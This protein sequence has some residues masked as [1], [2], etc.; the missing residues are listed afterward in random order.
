MANQNY[1]CFNINWFN[2]YENDLGHFGCAL[3]HLALTFYAHQ[4]KLDWIIVVEDDNIF[5]IEMSEVLNILNDLKMNINENNWKI[6]NGCPTMWN[7]MRLCCPI[8]KYEAFSPKF[9][10]L[11]WG[12]YTNFMIYSKWAYDTLLH[13][14]LTITLPTPCRN[15]IYLDEYS[16]ID[17]YI[18][19]Y[20]TTLTCLTYGK[21]ITGQKYSLSN[22]NIKN[23][24]EFHNLMY[25]DASWKT[26]DIIK[27]ISKLPIIGI[28]GIFINNYF[29]FYNDF[30]TN[31]NALFASDVHKIFFI[32]TDQKIDTIDTFGLNI[33]FLYRKHIGWPYETL[34]RY[35]YF[36]AFDKN[37]IDMCDYFFFL[38]SNAQVI[39]PISWKDICRPNMITCSLHNTYATSKIGMV[40]YERNKISTAFVN[41][42]CEKQYVGGR[43]FGAPREIFVELCE[44]LNINI[45]KDEKNNFI[46]KWH[47][48]SHLNWYVNVLCKHPI[49]MLPVEY[50]VPSQLIKKFYDPI[51]VYT[52]KSNELAI[53]T[54]R[55]K[56]GGKIIKNEYNQ[57]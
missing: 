19:T 53:G 22:V 49:Y 45:S 46:A 4:K 5:N 48:E 33:V 31:I 35:K 28:F 37:K 26:I 13:Y 54:T 56:I 51:I 1:D 44:V 50:H 10:F 24:S 47:D 16:H 39:R 21:F 2:A 11:S 43:L 20:F 55:S 18:P 3:S 40:P 14:P 42:L 9:T 30:I 38:N 29:K 32:V 23:T 12:Q 25:C 15:K 8:Y 7:P 6:F 27:N 36:L 17:T 34:Y 52:C 41:N 57:I